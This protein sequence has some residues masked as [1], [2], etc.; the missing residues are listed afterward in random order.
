MDG[1]RD[2]AATSSS[3]APPLLSQWT[4][5]LD[6]IGL[7]LEHLSILSVR[8]DGSTEVG[9][10]QRLIDEFNADTSITAFLLTTRAGGLGVNL[11]SA[12]TVSIYR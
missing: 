5:V 7:A 9:E 4:T 1:T 11:T 10:R 6:L 2:G 3:P 8:F 12:D